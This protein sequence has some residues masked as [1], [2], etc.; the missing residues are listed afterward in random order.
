MKYK[1]DLLKVILSFGWWYNL[2]WFSWCFK[3]S[4]SYNIVVHYTQAQASC[5]FL[6]PSSINYLCLNFKTCIKVLLDIQRSSLCN[7]A[8]IIFIVSCFTS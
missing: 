5:C 6:F 3:L 8:S 4:I 1:F 2:C 7:N